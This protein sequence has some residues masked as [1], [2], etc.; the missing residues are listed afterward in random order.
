M[1]NPVQ[2]NVVKLADQDRR[3]GEHEH[4]PKDQEGRDDDAYGPVRADLAELR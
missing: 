1:A 2:Q 3:Q 4:D